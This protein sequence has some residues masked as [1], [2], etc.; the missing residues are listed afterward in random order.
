[1][2]TPILIICFF[3]GLIV[4]VK[5]DKDFTEAPWTE[6]KDRC[7]YRLEF[8]NSVQKF[9]EFARELDLPTK[10]DKQQV[11][12]TI[13][14]CLH[15]VNGER[16]IRALSDI[17]RQLPAIHSVCET[18]FISQ[19]YQFNKRIRDSES[20]S[21]AFKRKSPHKLLRFSSLLT[22]QVVLTCK[23]NLEAK[24]EQA[25]QSDEDLRQSLDVVENDQSLRNVVKSIPGMDILK[26]QLP[27]NISSAMAIKAKYG[28]N[29]YVGLYADTQQAVEQFLN[30]KKSCRLVD[31]Y[32]QNSIYPIARFAIDGFKAGDDGDA[33]DNKLKSSP[34]VTRWLN[35][36]HYC[37]GVNLV[38][39]VPTFEISE[40][41][42]QK[43]SNQ[44][45]KKQLEPKRFE[46]ADK[47]E[48]IGWDLQC[49]FESQE[50]KSMGI[51]SWIKKLH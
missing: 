27:E 2:L 40:S 37:L 23:R 19:L 17:V 9:L 44:K 20:P 31:S 28:S 30:V 51:R 38:R 6:L 48:D 1:M 13:N 50:S 4:S 46:K 16:D 47:F 5:A 21:K 10:Q 42:A 11:T 34:R 12:K 22:G 39:A 8:M 41:L 15:N 7:I 43:I 14:D 3:G 33:T 36:A 25:E 24:L 45:E 26:V 29:T 35:V 18:E 32:A 49:T